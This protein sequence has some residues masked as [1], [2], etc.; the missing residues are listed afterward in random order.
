[1]SNS[2]NRFSQSPFLLYKKSQQ[3]IHKMKKA[4]FL[5][6]ICELSKQNN[7]ALG[8]ALLIARNEGYTGVDANWKDIGRENI[9]LKNRL[10]TADINISSIYRVCNLAEDFSID[11]MKRFFEGVVFYNSTKAMLVPSFYS[12]KNNIEDTNKMIIDSLNISCDLAK[13]YGIT[14]SIENFG[15][16]Q[17]PCGSFSQVKM[18]LDNVTNLYY[19]LDTGNYAYF[20]EDVLYA[21]SELKDRIVHVH[22]K[23]WCLSPFDE[24]DESTLETITN[25]KL[26]PSPIGRGIVPIKDCIKKLY[27]YE[28][29]GYLTAEFFGAK[30]MLNYLKISFP[31]NL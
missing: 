20:N 2:K 28:Y 1:M 17:S 6:H 14:I 7:I 3:G 8:E 27:E 16:F 26:Y 12:E 29:K 21:L 13:S 22:L 25:V 11:E 4:I 9:L 5:P 30:N 10:N 24:N 18:L 19:T 15:H 31:K 23:D